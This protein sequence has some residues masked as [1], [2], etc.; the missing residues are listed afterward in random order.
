M[1]WAHPAGMEWELFLQGDFLPTL[2]DA[3]EGMLQKSIYFTCP[4]GK[5]GR[6][7]SVM[8]DSGQSDFFTTSQTSSSE[9]GA[10][11][12]GRQHPVASRDAPLILSELCPEP[13]RSRE[14]PLVRFS[15]FNEEM[16]PNGPHS[17]IHTAADFVYKLAVASCFSHN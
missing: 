9:R 2:P 7:L 11:L 13:V 17:S 4:S 16:F 6:F 15:S 8:F 14:K 1:Y 5:R 3:P 10:A 12:D